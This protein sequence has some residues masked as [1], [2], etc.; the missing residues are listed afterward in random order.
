MTMDNNSASILLIGNE[1]LSGDTRD[2]NAW[3][4]SL[5]LN[6]LGVNLRSISVVPDNLEQ[7]IN[8]LS[9]L[10]NVS[11][12]IFTCGGIGPTSDDMTREAISM[13]TGQKLEQREECVEKLKNYA[14][15]HKRLLNENSFKQALFPK[16]SKI[17]PNIAGTAD[18]FLTDYQDSKI[19]T[20]PGVPKEVTIIFEDQI[21]N[22]LPSLYPNLKKRFEINLRLFGLSESFIGTAIDKLNLDNAIN[23][24]YRP[25]FPELLLVLNCEDEDLLKHTAHKIKEHIGNEYFY[26]EE[27]KQNL[28]QTVF[29]LLKSKSKTI[30]FAESCSGG[31]LA[32]AFVDIPGA[33]SVFLGSAVTYS[34]QSKQKILSV[35]SLDRYGAV[36]IEVAREMARGAKKSF[37]SDYA[38][39]ITG[40]AGPNGG[41]IEKP[42]GTTCIA[43]A[44]DN[45][46]ETFEFHFAWDR[47]RNR[48][49]SAYMA[50]ELLRRKLL[51]LRLAWERN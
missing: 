37:N 22:L 30:S 39:A 9:R 4:I 42:A 18:A 1:L 49:Y 3:F 29:K 38:I 44:D 16:N 13:L 20:L 19:I 33:S 35:S 26:C 47:E 7:I 12:L 31:L 36:S 43:I 24:A 34:N 14:K 6:E 23:I 28:A 5:K 40:I 15:Q 17:I 25:S 21:L 8:E 41:T 46:V 50:I 10:S 48:I 45:E 51:G 27:K 11:P 2:K 32:N